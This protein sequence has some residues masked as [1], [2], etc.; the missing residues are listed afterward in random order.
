MAMHRMTSITEFVK[1]AE[2]IGRHGVDDF[3]FGKKLFGVS[4]TSL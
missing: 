2:G 4:K 3:Q 1:L